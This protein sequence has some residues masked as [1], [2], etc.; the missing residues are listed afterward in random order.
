MNTSITD[1][2]THYLGLSLRSPLIPS[3][4]PLSDR[5]ESLKE[6]E[7]SG[8]GAVVLPSL[9]EEPYN[10][11]ALPPAEYLDKI[12]AAREYLTIPVI[13]SLNA[14]TLKGWAEYAAMIEKAGAHAIELNIYNLSLD[15]DVPPGLVEGGYVNAVKAVAAAVKIPIAVKLPPYFTSLTYMAKVLKEAGAKGLVFFNRFYQPD[16]D[17]LTL[18]S[19]HSFRL[20]TAA[21]NR[22]PLRWISLL[23]RRVQIDLAANTGIRS[24]EDVLKMVL[25]GARVT[26]V[27]SVLMQHGI[28]Y[29]K[30]IEEELREAMEESGYTSLGQICGSLSCQTSGEPGEAEREEYRKALQGYLLVRRPDKRTLVVPHVPQ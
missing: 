3:A 17:L 9:F 8:A 21:E 6:M 15:P 16:I 23:Y 18:G 13:A 1:I 11:H 5:I 14:S 2:S 26:Q 4:S 27:C 25:S 7:N 24:G 10:S 12:K 19:S 30:K 22:F 29:L 20:S 28:P